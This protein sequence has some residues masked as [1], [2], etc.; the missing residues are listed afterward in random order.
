MS[1][2]NPANRIPRQS[3]VGM[4][5]M[6]VKMWDPPT[7][8]PITPDYRSPTNPVPE[9]MA[10][11]G[12]QNTP[13]KP[14]TVQR[15]LL[16]GVKMRTWDNDKDMNWYLLHDQDNPAA[17][18]GNYP[19][20]TIRLP[21][22]IWFNAE[23]LGHGPPPHTIHWHGIEPTPMNDGVGHCS[24]EVGHY[25]Y[26]WQPN[27]IGFYFNHCHRNTVQHFEF[28]LF[29]ALLIDPPD[30]YFATQWNPN[31]PIGA[32]RDG[33]RRIA[34]NLSNL[35]GPGG[36]IPA[37]PGGGA[38]FEGAIVPNP[39]PGFVGG[40]ITDPDP[41]ADNPN[42][43]SYLKFPVNP[44]A[45]TVPYDVEALWVVDDR[46]SAWSDLAPDARA[47]YPKHGSIPGVNDNFHGDAGGG[48][49][50]SDF[51]AFNDFNPDYWFVTGV[52]VPAH[53][54]GVGTIPAGI[55]IPPA[56]ISGTATQ[57]SIEAQVN[58]TILVRVLDAAY[59]NIT[60][61]FPVDIT[62]I[63]WD[64]RALGVAPFN[65]YTH[66]YLVPA[67]TPIHT[68]VARRFDALIRVNS[69]I[70]DF[71]TVQF[72]D[73][74]CGTATGF[75]R[76]VL[77]TAKIPINIK[78]V[79]VAPPSEPTPT[80][81]RPRPVSPSPTPVPGTVESL[82]ISGW[83]AGTKRNE[84][85]P[86]I[87]INLTGAMSRVVFTGADGNFFFSGLKA[88]RYTITPSAPRYSFSPRYRQVTI[89]NTNKVGQSF[90]ARTR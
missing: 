75:E 29:N 52:P 23:T 3:V 25:T 38:G 90:R 14:H 64:G 77:C 69:P 47:T 53:R 7:E 34:A 57:V 85:I 24:M 76:P 78:G 32:G 81:V 35:R 16:H 73:T 89:R 87:Q 79:A 17:A 1:V 54:G 58:Q 10:A 45:M 66:S 21:R 28:G 18:S 50:P 4:E 20:A 60:V 5:G 6:W 13:S 9:V 11:A 59:N 70:S 55:V 49:G 80:P 72:T 40:L 33:N 74:R 61:T 19:G 67:N 36:P 51:F 56:L 37:N 22:G 42:L 39:F 2:S 86:G 31:I 41:E 82:S 88:G 43:P 12:L 30:A 65:E 8:S 44:H 84:P 26:Q 27:F 83:V 46:D 62:I 68:S 63:A 48:V 15:G 71:A